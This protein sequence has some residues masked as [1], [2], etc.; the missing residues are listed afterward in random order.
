[1]EKGIYLAFGALVI[2][3]ILDATSRFAVVG[4]G[5]HP[6]V[7]SCLNLL[8]GGLI[9]MAIGGKGWGNME[10][11]KNPLTY[12]FGFLR[13]LMTLFMVYAFAFL[14][15]SEAGFMLRI[16]AVISMLMVWVL[17]NR[18]TQKQ[19]I[20]G[21]FLI[22]GGFSLIALRQE[23]SLLNIGV[24]CVIGA[25]ICDALLN[26]V[27]EK[28]PISNRAV[29]FKARAR[30][31]GVV[32][33]ITSLI[34]VVA[35]VILNKFNLFTGNSFFALPSLHDVF[36]GPTLIAALF[37]GI[38]MRAPS[39][40]MHLL[41]NRLIKAEMVAMIFTLA[42]FSTLIA[43]SIFGL[44]GLLDVAALDG[45]DVLGGLHPLHQI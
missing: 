27:A 14:T 4:L 25:A 18:Q 17:F 23:L 40:Y 16:S 36:H 13:V 39:M 30:Y 3:G 15:A 28:H 45:I 35:A 6:F 34:S 8:F 33:T 26:I 42:T 10:T 9:L 19:D 22:L 37:V 41:A 32:L 38:F 24:L 11:L 2:W 7:F 5:A 43:E 21:I 31:T 1:M 29:G 44:F 12:T 20:P